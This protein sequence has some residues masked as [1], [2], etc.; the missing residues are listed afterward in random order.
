[1]F[2]IIYEFIRIRSNRLFSPTSFAYEISVPGIKTEEKDDISALTTTKLHKSSRPGLI[3]ESVHDWNGKTQHY[4]R[5][6]HGLMRYSIF[7]TLRAGINDPLAT[8]SW[9]ATHAP[10]VVKLKICR[11]TSSS[12]AEKEDQPRC[13]CFWSDFPPGISFNYYWQ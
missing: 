12:A 4:S 10:S 7:N 11:E 8:Y 5:P 6:K 13:S 3:P 1:M 2:L 9:H